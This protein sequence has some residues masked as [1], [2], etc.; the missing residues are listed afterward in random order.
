M[1][2]TAIAL[3][4]AIGAVM[5][6]LGAGGSILAVPALTF[7]LGVP[8]KDAVAMALM[9]VGVCAAIGAAGHWFRGTLPLKSALVMGLASSAGAFAGGAIGARLPDAVQLRLLAAVM[10][11]AAFLMWRVPAMTRVP[12][13]ALGIGV[14]LLTGIVGVGGGFMMVPALT[15]GAGLPIKKAAAASLFV[16]MLSAA[17]ALPNY[18]GQLSLQWRFLAPF[19]AIAATATLAGGAVAERLPQQRLRH[20]FAF[21]LV[22]LAS[23]VLIET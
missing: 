17:A 9:V 14:G 8:A 15:I 1:T 10:F 18:I 4:L 22:L 16:M 11:A 6:L 13:A 20:A 5:G 2:I 21:G 19:I 3:A 12:L 23:Y 7:L